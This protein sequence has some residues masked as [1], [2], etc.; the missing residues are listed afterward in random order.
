MNNEIS[1]RT[2]KGEYLPGETVHGAVYLLISRPTE[3]N[4]IQITFKG[5]ETCTYKYEHEGRKTLQNETAH[6]DFSNVNLYSQKEYFQFG[7]YVFPFKFELSKTIPGTFHCTGK[8]NG[9]EWEVD[10]SYVLQAQANT[11]QVS[12]K[13]VVYQVD[14]TNMQNNLLG[15][16]KDVSFSPSFFS[17]T[18][19]HITVRLIKNYVETGDNMMMRLILTNPSKLH[20]TGFSI[21]LLRY[22]KLYL[23]YRGTSEKQLTAN[24]EFTNGVIVVAPETGPHT[25]YSME[26]ESCAFSAGNSSLDRL[27]IPL[28]ENRINLPPSVEGKNVKSQYGLEVRVK[29]SNG[30]SETLLLPIPGVL[31]CKNEQWSQWCPPDWTFKAETKLSSSLFS[32]PEYLL[33]TEAFSGLPT[34]QVL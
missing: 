21:K 12:Q 31:P 17:K 26:G 10:V 27:Q 9:A 7:S 29:F 4:C 25:V 8:Q 11:M 3:A 5:I 2:V 18:R 20:V 30:H 14:E 23:T 22:L 19:V 15:Q 16:A 32:V 6:A 24:M 33:R 34:F 13:I 28:K 1:L